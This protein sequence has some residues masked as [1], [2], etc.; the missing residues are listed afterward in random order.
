[1]EKEKKWLRTIGI[2]KCII[3]I[4]LL[5]IPFYGIIMLATGIYLYIESKE[6]EE[7][8]YENKFL[9]FLL[10]ILTIVDVLGSIAL[11]V[12]T[13]K[14][15]KYK[16]KSNGNKASPKKLTVTKESR[17][18]DIIQKIGLLMILIAGVLL[19][20][21]PTTFISGTTK[22]II[23]L[24]IGIS[25]FITS[26]I[27]EKKYKLTKSSETYWALSMTFIVLSLVELLYYETFGNYISFNGSGKNIAYSITF[28][29]ISI[30]LLITNKKYKEN[31]VLFISYASF[32]LGIY[33]FLTYVGLRQI[34]VIALFTIITVFINV[35]SNSKG[36]IFNLSKII[37]YI[38]IGFLITQ[39][40]PNNI[41]ILYTSIISIISI[42]YLTFIDKTK[43][44][45][46]IN[47]IVT[48]I[49]IFF[50]LSNTI[51]S[52][53]LN[54]VLVSLISS[55][56]TLLI[57]S[58]IVPIKEKDININ[59]II[60]SILTIIL[61][62]ITY[63]NQSYLGPLL[64]T[65][66]YIIVNV[67][68]KR[69]L[70]NTYKVE[71]SSFLEP[72]SFMGLFIAISTTLFRNLD[73]IYAISITTL[74]YCIIHHI[75]KKDLTKNIYYISIITG[76]FITLIMCSSSLNLP[77]TIITIISSLY[78]FCK[79]L[80]DKHNKKITKEYLAIS[81]IFML[82]SLFVPFV[83]INILNINIFLI[84]F[85]FVFVML[86]L[87]IIV[88]AQTVSKIACVYVVFP[89]LS[90]SLQTDM[91]YILGNILNSFILLYMAYIVI[92]FYINNKVL[93]NIISILCILLFTRPLFF[94]ANLYAIIF[95]GLVGVISIIIGIRKDE[96]FPLFITGIIY[97]IVNIIYRF[98]LLLDRMPY[99]LYLL[100]GGMLLVI[101]VTYSEIK[102][103]A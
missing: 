30:L 75:T 92:K 77:T 59:F 89:L 43:D 58:Y 60:Y 20:A 102:K 34:E 50:G 65:L 90:I 80:V 72:V 25:F 36:N 91:S 88:D 21:N 62:F 5:N 26:I 24:V 14:I 2:L 67:I 11:F 100:I 94:E 84:S 8:I 97:T 76:L 52:E 83:Y 54:L 32:L 31:P 87:V 17:K 38:L 16:I 63:S 42:N 56:Y 28:F 12:V 57:N 3:G 101:Y 93:K 81:S 86:L 7:K 27:V 64:I 69:G 15:N 10:S 19:A 23:L 61:L 70:F 41:L 40:H 73:L 98:W 49:L 78:I 9:L 4:P 18:K 71:I 29:V 45:S 39:K 55:I 85:L 53:S 37:T 95:V 82:T 6:K 44:E 47:I 79:S 66:T 103:D 33:Y 51:M 68:S 96:L 1:M 74:V 22:A 35:F 48:Y 99:W 46:L 13:Y